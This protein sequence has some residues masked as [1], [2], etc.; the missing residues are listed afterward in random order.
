MLLGSAP[1]SLMS[2]QDFTE[3]KNKKKDNKKKKNKPAAAA[4]LEIEVKPAASI[5]TE[6]QA[7]KPTTPKQTS[8]QQLPMS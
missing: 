6:V 1:P 4:N 7:P 3:I 8:K 2:K 5:Q